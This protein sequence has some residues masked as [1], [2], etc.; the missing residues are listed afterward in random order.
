MPEDDAPL[1]PAR[2]RDLTQWQVSKISTIGARLTASRMPLHGRSDY[3]LLAALDE[4]GP[5][6]QAE[7]GRRLGVDRNDVNGVVNRLE[8]ARHVDRE[9]DP[10]DRRRNIITITRAGTTYLDGLVVHAEDVQNELLHALDAGERQQLTSLLSKVLAG[11]S[12]QPA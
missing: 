6:S 1:S 9:T 4:Y 3:A 8:A 2:L 5:L 7:L 11:H 12:P 10:A